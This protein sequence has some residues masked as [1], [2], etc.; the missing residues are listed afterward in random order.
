MRQYVCLNTH[1]HVFPTFSNRTRPSK[2]WGFD[3]APCTMQHQRPSEIELTLDMQIGI[4]S[5]V[6]K[7]I[8]QRQWQQ[9]PF[10]KQRNHTTMLQQHSIQAS[11]TVPSSFLH[12]EAVCV[13]AMSTK[14]SRKRLVC[15]ARGVPGARNC[16][17]PAEV[18][19]LCASVSLHRAKKEPGK[20]AVRRH[21]HRSQKNSQWSCG[22]GTTRNKHVTKDV[23]L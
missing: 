8:E 10:H 22:P 20:R 2:S 23:S 4:I 19:M 21:K 1:S 14:P 7:M 5:T 6:H 15:G 17:S 13:E 3:I 12:E 16:L 18:Q 9:P 11:A